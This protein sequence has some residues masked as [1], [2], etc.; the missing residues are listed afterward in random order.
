MG[1][2]ATWKKHDRPAVV[3]VRHNY[4]HSYALGRDEHTVR[5]AP[6]SVPAHTP[7]ALVHPA[8]TFARARASGTDAG[9]T[10]QR[11]GT[12]RV[13]QRAGLVAVRRR[14]ARRGVGLGNTRWA[15][16]VFCLKYDLVARRS[17]FQQEK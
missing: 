15:L 5:P 10:G 11:W 2:G 12:Q 1:P 4:A 14:P 3:T 16:D 13:A 9:L 8:A 7:R 17:L 6:L